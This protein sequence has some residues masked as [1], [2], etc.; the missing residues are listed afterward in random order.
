MTVDSGSQTAIAPD[1]TRLFVSERGHGDDVLFIPGL[2]YAA[3][4]WHYQAEDGGRCS[5]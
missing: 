2:G 5:S 1:G 4:C 3:W